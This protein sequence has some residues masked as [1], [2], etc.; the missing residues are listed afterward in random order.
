M[1]YRFAKSIGNYG[2]SDESAAYLIEN[3]QSFAVGLSREGNKKLPGLDLINMAS[4]LNV[5][6]LF[7]STLST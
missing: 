7:L 3:N 4:A 1:K 5:L 2:I 6:Q